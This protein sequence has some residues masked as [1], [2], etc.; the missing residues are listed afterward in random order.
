VE[1]VVELELVVQMVFLVMEQMEDLVVEVLVVELVQHQF[2]VT[3][4]LHL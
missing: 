3:V 1:V 2:M 4:I